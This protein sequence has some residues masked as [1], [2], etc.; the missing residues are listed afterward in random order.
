LLENSSVVQGKTLPDACLSVF[1]G[2]PLT[3]DSL[4][5]Y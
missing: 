4:K 2:R 3:T 5:L 1:S